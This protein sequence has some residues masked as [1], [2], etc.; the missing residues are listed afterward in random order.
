MWI[1]IF[2]EHERQFWYSSNKV[3][4][5]RAIS[6]RQNVR[7]KAIRKTRTASRHRTQISLYEVC[8][9]H[10]TKRMKTKLKC[11][12]KNEYELYRKSIYITRLDFETTNRER[13]YDKRGQCRRKN[14]NRMKKKKNIRGE[15]KM[16][17]PSYP[18]NRCD[19]R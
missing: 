13:P 14:K 9:V 5:L 6:R 10:E 7:K 19:L 17:S 12:L 18:G 3:R 1:K 11:T 4:F 2:A 16:S 15:K 8:V